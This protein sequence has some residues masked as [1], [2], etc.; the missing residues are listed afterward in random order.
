MWG[1]R[2]YTKPLGLNK[3]SFRDL[4]EQ[5]HF[6]RSPSLSRMPGISPSMI[7]LRSLENCE[8]VSLF[9]SFKDTAALGAERCLQGPSEWLDTSCPG[10]RQL[11]LRDIS[12]SH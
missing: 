1:L 3:E 6:Q 11:L 5:G 10:P 9:F 8:R 7:C 12:A 4:G 2:F